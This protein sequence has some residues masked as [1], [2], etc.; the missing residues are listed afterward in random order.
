MNRR[1]ET[2]SQLLVFTV[3][4]LVDMI[5]R[6]HIR[7]P[8][9]ARRYVWNQDQAISLFDSITRGYPIGTLLFSEG[10]AP[11]EEITFGSLHV[12]GLAEERAYWVV[13][14]QQRLVSLVSALTDSYELDPRFALAFDLRSESFVANPAQPHP[15]VV[16]LPVLFDSFAL[17]RWLSD[18]S[19]DVELIELATGISSNIRRFQVAVHV[20]Q[21]ENPAV[22]MEIFER[23]N[24][25]GVSLRPTDLFSALAT[26]ASPSGR[27]RNVEDTAQLVA[28]RTGFGSIDENTIMRSIL[29]V[30]ST[31]VT[32]ISHISYNDLNSAYDKGEEA[33][34]RAVVFLQETAEVPHITFLASNY[35]LVALTRFFALHANPD[36]QN[37]RL[38]RRWLWRA[39]LMSARSNT[40]RNLTVLRG[41]L[42]SIRDDRTSRT[43]QSMLQ[44]L[45]SF[46][47]PYPDVSKF[48]P[49]TAATRLLLC[50]W[51]SRAPRDFRTGNPIGRSELSAVVGNGNSAARAVPLIVKEN[52]N[53]ALGSANRILLPSVTGGAVDLD[54]FLRRSPKSTDDLA[55]SQI[56]SSHLITEEAL[57]LMRQR[58]I[59]DFWRLREGIIRSQLE[60]FLDSLCEWGF[61]NT[62][63]LND[64]IIEEDDDDGLA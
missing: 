6:G 36:T 40:G 33:L 58:R 34:I 48:Q 5:R 55:W 63:S 56:L 22:T 38:L 49:R 17:R 13:D 32:K 10:P 53:R 30:R 43:L 8:A 9:Y 7:I 18:G 28:E 52:S 11:H 12:T 61:E 39:S 1:Y 41:Y 60:H 26:S 50:S 44:H 35:L 64:L 23:L 19:V 59:E 16:P 21:N 62:P 57:W 3:E 29:A 51:W 42:G 37:L 25:S 2:A 14:G 15:Y 20:I 54:N 4:Y 47:Q 45:D 27:A 31:D 46:R 24:T